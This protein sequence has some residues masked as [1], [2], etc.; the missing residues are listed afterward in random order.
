MSSWRHSLRN[1]PPTLEPHQRRPDHDRREAPHEFL[2]DQTAPA[3]S[4][5]LSSS[6]C[7]FQRPLRQ[8]APADWAVSGGPLLLAPP[9]LGRGLSPRARAFGWATAAGLPAACVAADAALATSAWTSKE[10]AT[11]MVCLSSSSAACMRR[12]AALSAAPSGS[13]TSPAR[14]RSA[15]L[16]PLFLAAVLLR[17]LSGHHI[18]TPF[19][20]ALLVRAAPPAPVAVVPPPGLPSGRWTDLPTGAIRLSVTLVISRSPH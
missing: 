17:V 18:G 12:A 6:S 20:R 14:I 11:R 19:T 7:P 1:S 3:T 4:S 16:A 15:R 2:D 13:A 9:G 10:D 8:P 5:A